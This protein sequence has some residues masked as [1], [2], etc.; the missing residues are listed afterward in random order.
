MITSADE[1][2]NFYEPCEAKNPLST[3]Y[4]THN[5]LEYLRRNRN[6]LRVCDMTKVAITLGERLEDIIQHVLKFG[7]LCESDM[8]SLRIALATRYIDIHG[9][10]IIKPTMERKGVLLCSVIGG[11][12]LVFP[13]HRAKVQQQVRTSTLY[14]LDAP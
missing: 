8:G 14:L 7:D 12:K 13:V 10:K 2:H 9:L 5:S 6:L 3:Q 1:L 11:S 4:C